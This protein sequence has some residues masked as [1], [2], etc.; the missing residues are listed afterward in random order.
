MIAGLGGGIG[1]GSLGLTPDNPGSARV[2]STVEAVLVRH[3]MIVVDDQ[4]REAG[5]W[6]AYEEVEMPSL[7]LLTR[8]EL[9]GIGNSAWLFL[10]VVQSN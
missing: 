8:M 10:P 9:N 3:L 2:R 4:L 6:P 5:L 7:V 1:V